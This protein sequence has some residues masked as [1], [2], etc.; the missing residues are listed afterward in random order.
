MRRTIKLILSLLLIVTLFPTAASA[1]DVYTEGYFKYRIEDDSV[2]I[3]DYFGKEAEVTVPAAIVGNPVSKIAKGAFDDNSKVK[4]VN[5]PDTI[6]SVENGAFASG[7]S[8]VYNSNTDNPVKSGAG[9]GMNSGEGDN[10]SS[11]SKGAA[12]S[13]SSG[14]D[15]RT[16]VSEDSKGSSQPG[17]EEI[18]AELEEDDIDNAYGGNAISRKFRELADENGYGVVIAGIVIIVLVICGIGYYV[19]RKKKKRV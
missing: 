13:N 7:I 17:I 18:E 8:V 6:M 12:D 10:D 16:S 3:C 9:G 11:S 1:S 15:S 4:K 19:W 2:T 14:K 5:L